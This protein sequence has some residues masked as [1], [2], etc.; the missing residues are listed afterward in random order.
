MPSMHDDGGRLFGGDHGRAQLHPVVEIGAHQAGGFAGPLDDGDLRPLGGER[1]GESQ[2]ELVGERIAEHQH[3]FARRIEPHAVGIGRGVEHDAA[4]A[5]GGRLGQDPGR[6]LPR[7]EIARRVDQSALR[8]E[9]IA[10]HEVA[11]VA[12]ILGRRRRGEGRQRDKQCSSMDGP[13]HRVRSAPEPERWP[14]FAPISRLLAEAFQRVRR[15]RSKS[16]SVAKPSGTSPERAWKSR[17]AARVPAPSRP[18][19]SPR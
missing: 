10:Q 18:S 9:R 1:V 8:P 7:I 5:L 13:D 17:T 3:V 15:R 16:A 12:R 19:A 2:R 14:S 6:Q 11:V 4:D